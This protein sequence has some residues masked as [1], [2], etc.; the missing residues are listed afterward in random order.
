VNS[1]GKAAMDMVY[2]VRRQFREIPGIMEGTGKIKCVDIST[3]A[4]LK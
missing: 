3:K 4:A 2:E 1:V